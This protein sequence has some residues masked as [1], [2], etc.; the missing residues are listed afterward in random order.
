MNRV[1]EK[2]CALPEYDSGESSFY[3][4]TKPM[5]NIEV[6]T[7]GS[8]HHWGD[9]YKNFSTR[10][11]KKT[12]LHEMVLSETYVPGMTNKINAVVKR[13]ISIK[14]CEPDRLN[15]EYYRTD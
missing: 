13:C 12:I 11:I 9:I 4:L 1:N 7:K 14:K 10:W 5:A 6:T 15:F 2:A 3:M 8:S